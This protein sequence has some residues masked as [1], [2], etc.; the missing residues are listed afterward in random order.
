MKN[1]K[2]ILL[3]NFY[4]WNAI[5][6]YKKNLK[7]SYFQFFLEFFSGFFFLRFYSFNFQ[8]SVSVMLLML[9]FFCWCCYYF[10]LSSFSTS[11]SNPGVRLRLICSCALWIA[12]NLFLFVI[13]SFSAFQ[14][15]LP[16]SFHFFPISFPFSFLRCNE[17]INFAHFFP[18]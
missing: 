18:K 16:C 3:S 2:S 6:V 7:A 8:R 12:F 11:H 5:L 14:K 4:L 13:T 17:I 9:L 15:S 10:V 1:P